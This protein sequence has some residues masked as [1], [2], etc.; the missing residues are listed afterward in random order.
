MFTGDPN[1]AY[2][3]LTLAR[4]VAD[5]A[6]QVHHA[7]PGSAEQIKGAADYAVFLRE[8][9]KVAPLPMKAAF[10]T[11]AA[12]NLS[13]LVPLF[14]KYGNDEARFDR[15]ASAA[16][17]KLAQ[18]DP[19]GD[20]D[21]A[22]QTVLRYE[23]QVCGTGGPKSADVKFT[24]SSKGAVCDLYR[25]DQAAHDKWL[26]S[27]FSAKANRELFAGR[28][29]IL[30]ARDRAAAADE[31]LPASIRTAIHAYAVHYRVRQLPVLEKFGY[32]WFQAMAH[33]TADDRHAITDS[34]ADIWNQV[35]LGSAYDDQVCAV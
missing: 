35:A 16:E 24:G 29:P 9:E 4:A 7:K 34:D 5:N 8:G 23:S 19:P 28:M 31:S 27:D 12:W 33:G 15:E 22:F 6:A 14:A 25:K 32:D 18:S 13:T 17:K 10:H 1:G 20:A 26:D 21:T 2:C 11:Y 3:R 30:D